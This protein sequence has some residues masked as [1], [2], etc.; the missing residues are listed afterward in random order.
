MAGGGDHLGGVVEDRIRRLVTCGAALPLRMVA[1]RYARK[2]H[3]TAR[4][5][6]SGVGSWR[7][8]GRWNAPGAFHAV[9]LSSHHELAHREYFE[10][11]RVT[12]LGAFEGMPFEGH[13]IDLNLGAVLD[14]RD[15][16]VL[17]TLDVS[18]RALVD[19]DWK[20][21]ADQGG[22][23]LCQAIGAGALACGLQG[24]IVPSARAVR[25]DEFNIVLIAENCPADP[26]V[27][28]IITDYA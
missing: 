19:D 16:A 1:Y 26:P 20:A 18:S 25:P 22:L 11:Y 15:E 27:W 24:L 10:R 21:S 6:M 14:L 12:S 3:A 8:G 5:L 17:E 2:R 7:G 13:A 9:Y 23:S 28:R 4:Q